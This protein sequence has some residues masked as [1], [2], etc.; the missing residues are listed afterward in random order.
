MSRGGLTARELNNGE[1]NVQL[2]AFLL[3]V[4]MAHNAPSCSPE[5]AA[6]IFRFSTPA[7]EFGPSYIGVPVSALYATSFETSCSKLTLWFQ[8]VRDN[9]LSGVLLLLLKEGGTR[10]MVLESLGMLRPML[11]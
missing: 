9:V 8:S 5:A 6:F 3:P 2:S 11:F 7:D 10:S 1:H 4:A